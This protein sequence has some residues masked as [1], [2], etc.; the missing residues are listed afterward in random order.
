MASGVDFA[1][2]AT[3]MN[4]AYPSTINGQEILEEDYNEDFEPTDEGLFMQTLK[5]A[6]GRTSPKMLI[7]DAALCLLFRCDRVLRPVG[8]GS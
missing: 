3:S 5:L 4:L 7:Y 2:L 6:M 1:H 8:F